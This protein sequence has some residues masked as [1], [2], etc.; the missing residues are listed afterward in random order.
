MRP[1]PAFVVSAPFPGSFSDRLSSRLT[2]P[3]IPAEMK[4]TVKSA[5]GE[6]GFTLV[7]L[8]VVILIIGVLA[9]IAIPV[10][11]NQ[12]GKAQG[13]NGKEEAR[14]AAQAAETYSTDHSGK[15]NG[16]TPEA[17][18]EYEPALRVSEGG[19]NEAWVSAAKEAESG[20]G[21]SVTATA[22]NGDKFTWSKTAG[23]EVA[24]TCEVKAGNA[25]SSCQTGSW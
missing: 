10:F 9:A 4:G 14:A 5:A 2:A 22:P 17:L 15:Y 18:R 11:L 6:R 24:R 7:E 20:S 13:A 3:S 25:K 12:K 16:L 19:A 23:G 21:Y 1:L 8:L